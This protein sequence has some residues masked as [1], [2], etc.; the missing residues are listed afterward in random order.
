MTKCDTKIVVSRGRKSERERKKRRKRK[1]D[2]GNGEQD[3]V[4]PDEEE[5]MEED[6]ERLNVSEPVETE[7]ATSHEESENVFSVTI[8][9][10]TSNSAQV[11]DQCQSASASLAAFVP[12]PRMNTLLA[13][14]HGVLYMY[15]GIYE[16][17][18]KQITL[19]DMYSLDLHKLDEW[20]V[21]IESDLDAK[22]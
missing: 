7:A 15:G 5:E 12:H 4:S 21:L 2:I 22:V 8:G 6:L 20:N 18:D 17:G 10:Q 3:S 1:A 13:V 16:A 9:P 19:S 11:V 14:K